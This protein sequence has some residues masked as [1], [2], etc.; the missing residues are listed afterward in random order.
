LEPGVAC[1]YNGVVPSVPPSHIWQYSHVDI[2]VPIFRAAVFRKWATD[3]GG[4]W[5]GEVKAA[6]LSGLTKDKLIDINSPVKP[7]EHFAFPLVPKFGPED[8]D[9]LPQGMTFVGF[10]S[11]SGIL[12]DFP[13]CDLRMLPV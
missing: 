1:V 6:L 13:D 4:F 3:T 11:R 8:P 10:N 12:A 5:Y 2:P 9:F 7:Q